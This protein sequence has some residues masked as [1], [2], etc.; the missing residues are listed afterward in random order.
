MNGQPDEEIHRA[1]SQTE[2]LLSLWSLGPGMVAHRKVLVLQPGS[3]SN[4]LL[5]GFYYVG[6]IDQ[7]M[8]H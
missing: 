5:W 4:P 6:M 3:S 1:K 8:G 2:K 7:I